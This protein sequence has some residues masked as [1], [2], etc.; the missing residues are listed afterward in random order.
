MDSSFNPAIE[1]SCTFDEIRLGAFINDI[2]SVV[3][4][5]KNTL[6]RCYKV[7]T[8]RTTTLIVTKITVPEFRAWLRNSSRDPSHSYVYRK[9][10]ASL[11]R[12]TG[13]I[14]HGLFMSDH[15]R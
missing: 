15:I 14:L 4:L 12:S 3:A 1:L 11:I 6:T 5:D 9:D 2:W 13:V 8:Y 7:A 10:A